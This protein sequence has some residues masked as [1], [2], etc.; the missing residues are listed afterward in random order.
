MLSKSF[1]LPSFHNTMVALADTMQDGENLALLRF[2]SLLSQAVEQIE[3][4]LKQNRS[5]KVVTVRCGY[6][7]DRN[8]ARGRHYAAH[9]GDREPVSRSSSFTMMRKWLARAGGVLRRL[10]SDTRNPKDRKPRRF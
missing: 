6:H 10:G 1:R 9:P 7:E 5:W 2:L 3:T 8:V 4:R